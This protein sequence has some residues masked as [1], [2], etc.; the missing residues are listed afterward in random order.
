MLTG[1]SWV[2]LFPFKK[3]ILYLPIFCYK[4]SILKGRRRRTRWGRSTR[5]RGRGGEE[6][7]GEEEEKEE[8][9]EIME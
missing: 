9:K 1:D 5:G 8:G 4:N 7:E 3:Y 6:K 2:I